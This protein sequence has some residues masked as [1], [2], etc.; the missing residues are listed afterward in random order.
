MKR[1]ILS[2]ILPVFN[3]Q[4]FLS[5]AIESV[6]NQEK[7]PFDLEIIAIDDG[8][9][10]DSIKILKELKRNHPCII[11]IQLTKNKGPASAR[12][13]GITKATGE[14]LSFIDQDDCWAKNKLNV[15]YEFLSAVP[16]IDY[17]ISYQKFSLHQMS[18]KPHWVKKEWL[19]SPQTGYVFGT[20]LIKKE[21]FLKI[22]LD[23]QKNT[24]VD[25]VQWFVDA[26]FYGLKMHIL[27]DVLLYRKITDNNFSQH[28]KEHNKSL[29]S[30][31]RDKIHKE[32]L[33]D[34]ICE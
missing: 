31:I 17:V 28:T 23:P 4:Q 6:V 13:S 20:L 33:M 24:G 14:W 1:P 16:M 26:K 30:I 7:N 9:T 21:L 25:D 8:S 32:T 11:I 18:K 12:S 22:G 2:V 3:G 5:D 27:P 34:R 15:Q 10:D 19:D 29:L